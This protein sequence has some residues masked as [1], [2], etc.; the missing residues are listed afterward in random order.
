MLIFTYHLI[1]RNTMESE[2]DT[3][4]TK[5]FFKYVPTP[6]SQ[7]LPIN[8]DKLK[9]ETVPTIS[10][11]SPRKSPRKS[12]SETKRHSK[13]G[14]TSEPLAQKISHFIFRSR[15]NSVDI[16]TTP[17]IR[18]SVGDIKLKPKPINDFNH[19]KFNTTADLNPSRSRS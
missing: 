5:K 4:P 1:I 6:N 14:E 16:A 10:S 11:K 15:E 19:V 18:K 3:P 13:D 2:K 8:S 12:K 7:P 9:S 17:E